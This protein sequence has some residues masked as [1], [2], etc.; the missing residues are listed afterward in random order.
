[1]ATNYSYTQFNRDRD[2]LAPL[3]ALEYVMMRKDLNNFMHDMLRK[4]YKD[5][6]TLGKDIS[7]NSSRILLFGAGFSLSV[8]GFVL[9]DH[10]GW[11]A[12][13]VILGIIMLVAILAIPINHLLDQASR[14]R[15]RKFIINSIKS[16]YLFH[17]NLIRTSSTY[18]EYLEEVPKADP[19]KFQY[20]F[21]KYAK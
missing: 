5:E 11:I 9:F 18:N 6:I 12:C 4:L 20:Y 17:Y 10:P 13:S 21:R 8:A 1:M 19:V 15:E 14:Q 3:A 2:V 16:Y 7:L